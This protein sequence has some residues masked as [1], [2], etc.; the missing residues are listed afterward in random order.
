MLWK[1][2]M[3]RLSA[4][5]VQSVATRMIVE[6]ER[7]RMRFRAATWWDLEGTFDAAGQSFA[8]NLVAVGGTAVATGRDF[9]ETGELDRD[10]RGAASARPRPRGLAAGTWP[11]RPSR[12]A[13]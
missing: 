13:P 7:A 11:A 9:A 6:R 8:A 3:P 1:K 10:R 5:R 2:V 12:C 4:G